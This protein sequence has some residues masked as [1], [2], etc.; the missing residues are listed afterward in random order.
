MLSDFF[1]F[2]IVVV[3]IVVVV[4]VVAVIAVVGIVA[5]MPSAH[6]LQA[7]L[8]VCQLPRPKKAKKD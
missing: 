5:H 1:L 4:I 6:K 8:S 7:V 3:A 2:N